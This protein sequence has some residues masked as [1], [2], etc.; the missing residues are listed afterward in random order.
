M[1]TRGVLDPLAVF[2]PG[3]PHTEG[4]EMR[5]ITEREAKTLIRAKIKASGNSRLAVAFWGSGACE[6]LQI[7]QNSKNVSI[8]CN[9][10]MGGTNPAEI[11][12]MIKRGIKITQSDALHA[13]VYLFDDGVLIGS[14]NASSNGLSFQDGEL[15]SWVEAN[16]YI[17]E[18][19]LLAAVSEWFGRIE[20]RAITPKDLAYAKLQWR[21]RRSITGS[22]SSID[23]NQSIFQKMR[24]ASTAFDDREI[25]AC[26]YGQPMMNAEGKRG[27]KVAKREFGNNVDAFQNFAGLP[28]EGKLL[29]FCFG[30]RGGLKFQDLWR[31][32]AALPDQPLKHSTLQ[33]VLQEKN[34]NELIPQAADLKEWRDIFKKIR[35]SEY[36]NENNSSAV[37]DFAVIARNFLS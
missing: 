35:Q 13:K 26:F 1:M 34:V 9:L 10:R 21:K 32:D 30:P 4:S 22:I 25:F 27:L 23:E 8:I 29:C 28:S 33:L 12:E 11:E 15:H 2:C 7:E 19:Q 14:S 36:W 5:F 20:T 6:E 24:A 17:E 3:L 18:D 31:R 37:V 16:V